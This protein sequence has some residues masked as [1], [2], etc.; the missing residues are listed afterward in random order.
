[1]QKEN[2]KSFQTWQVHQLGVRVKGKP[3]VGNAGHWQLDSSAWRYLGLRQC[4][5]QMRPWSGLQLPSPALTQAAGMSLAPEALTSALEHRGGS[6][7]GGEDLLSCQ[8]SRQQQRPKLWPMERVISAQAVQIRYG[9]QE[10]L[11]GHV[12]GRK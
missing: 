5:H 10:I 3:K 8:T 4:L 7:Q 9:S 6:G 12:G 2:G 1:M 11:F